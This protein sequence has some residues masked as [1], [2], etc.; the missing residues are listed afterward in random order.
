M[1][2]LLFAM[3]CVTVIGCSRQESELEMNTDRLDLTGRS[4][5]TLAMLP[6][7]P[8]KI[9]FTVTGKYVGILNSY[10]GAEALKN[11]VG[12]HEVYDVVDAGG[13]YVG[14]LS[15]KN[16]QFL[17]AAATGNHYV[18]ANGGSACDSDWEK[19]LVEDGIGGGFAFKC[20]AN[21][22]YLNVENIPN[23]PIRAFADAINTWETFEVKQVV[24]MWQAVTAFADN[25]PTKS[26]FQGAGPL[27]DWI[28]YTDEKRNGTY[29]WQFELFGTDSRYPNNE[30]PVWNPYS[31]MWIGEWE[32]LVSYGTQPKYSPA[33][34]PA[35]AWTI[36]RCVRYLEPVASVSPSIT[37][38]R[39][40]LN[41][42]SCAKTSVATPNEYGSNSAGYVLDL[43]NLGSQENMG[44]R[45]VINLHYRNGPEYFIYDLGPSVGVF[46]PKYGI[47]GYD[48]GLG[49]WEHY[50]NIQNRPAHDDIYCLSGVGD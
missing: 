23:M 8:V 9:R 37:R 3:W 28:K 33:D 26:K 27:T 31:L 43:S 47:V 22:K 29:L 20:K 30:H 45:W 44:S 13:G 7:G 15:R 25:F 19:F 35:S 34:N 32:V 41:L 40:L 50:T 24:D 46:A 12:T 48:N 10:N 14:L 38:N 36:P 11:G 21:N 17:Q 1:K 6:N 39:Y 2:K 4:E 16:G 42:S 49:V 18:Y 5:A